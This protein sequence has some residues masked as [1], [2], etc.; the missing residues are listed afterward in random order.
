MDF[1]AAQQASIPPEIDARINQLSKKIPQL[2]HSPEA[3]VFMKGT[4]AAPRCGFSNMVVSIFDHPYFAR[5]KLTIKYVD[6]LNNPLIREA[7]KRANEWQTI[8]QIYIKGEFVGGC[9]ILIELANSD[10]LTKYIQKVVDARSPDAALPEK[11]TWQ[12]LQV[13]VDSAA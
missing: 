10:E 1:L 9:D 3:V 7:V 11:T 13:E 8:P 12:P 6:V 2:V 4:P 5:H